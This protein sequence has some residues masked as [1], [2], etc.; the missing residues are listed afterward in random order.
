MIPYWHEESWHL[1]WPLWILA[2]CHEKVIRAVF[3][4]LCQQSLWIVFSKFSA[5]G[6][7]KHTAV[8]VN[9]KI[10]FC[11]VF[12]YIHSSDTIFPA[13]SDTGFSFFR[14]E[15][16][17]WENF[18]IQVGKSGSQ[19]SRNECFILGERVWNSTL[20]YASAAPLERWDHRCITAKSCTANLNLIP[21]VSLLHL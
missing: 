10:C 12:T 14:P 6:S 1:M 11:V 9:V 5:F 2:L 19:D 3:I 21:S 4:V 13:W 18:S 7:C 17:I 15:R 20:G 16:F 8:K